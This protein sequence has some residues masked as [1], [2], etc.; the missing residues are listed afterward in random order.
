MKFEAFE[1]CFYITLN[2][3][4]FFVPL[5]QS[6]NDRVPQ[7]LI[8]F[9]FVSF[10]C[11][12]FSQVARLQEENREL[13]SK[14]QSLTDSSGGIPLDLSREFEQRVKRLEAELEVVEDQRRKATQ[15]VVKLQSQL[16]ESQHAAR[17][18]KEVLVSEVSCSP[19]ALTI[20]QKFRF[21]ILDFLH[22][23]WNATF[24]LYRPDPSH[25]A[26]GYYTRSRDT[27]ERY[28]NNNFVKWKGK[29]RCYQPK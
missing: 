19:C 26:F 8:F 15:E 11:F 13:K 27:E 9:R 1:V 28:W 2:D 18:H 12:F 6:R 24:R 25:R 21:Q 16:S 4:I 7:F 5:T 17:G 14:I 3:P 23:Y 29:F 20:E 22:D 10:C